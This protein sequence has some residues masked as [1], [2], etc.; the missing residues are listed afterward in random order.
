MFG[1][2][3]AVGRFLLPMLLAQRAEVLALTRAPV[4]PGVASL[5]WLQGS[6]QAA[7]AL[8]AVLEADMR[9]DVICSLGPLDAFADW[10]HRHPYA[11]AGRVLALSSLSAEWKQQ[12]A[13]H[14]ERALARSLAENEQRVLRQCPEATLLRCGLIHGAGVDRSL[15]PLLRWAR[16]RP[17]PWPRAARG[18][19]Q[20]V[21]AADLAR[22]VLAA[23]A[24]PQL[25]QRVLALPGPEALSF[26]VM[27][28]R[29]LAAE[30]RGSR[31]IPVPLPGL[32]WLAALLAGSRG[33]LGARAA[34]VRRLYLDQ[35]S[36]SQ[37]WDALGISL[38]DLRRVGDAAADE[39]QYR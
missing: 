23:A 6:L 3:G 28:Q 26:P 21:H 29:S 27:L 10:L 18:L 25:A 36:A 11:A 30:G 24:R 39:F 22:A 4:P 15:S 8:D 17:L 1:G 20:P 19:R 35:L 5:R 12:S 34:T 14:A 9:L 38:S 33:R 31:L 37:G 13:N 2:S 7:P 16:R 32:E